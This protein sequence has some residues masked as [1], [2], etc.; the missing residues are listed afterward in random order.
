MRTYRHFHVYYCFACLQDEFTLDLVGFLCAYVRNFIFIMIPEHV[1]S[2][3]ITG[4]INALFQ[5]VFQELV[6]AVIK[7]T[8][9][10]R[11]LHS[12]SVRDTL[13]GNR[14]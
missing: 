1:E 14:S 12:C 11:I 10:N 6:L 9:E 2:Q 5:L 8:L 7:H 3:A 4:R 13:L